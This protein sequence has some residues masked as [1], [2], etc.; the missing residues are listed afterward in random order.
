MTS[1]YVNES[2]TDMRRKLLVKAKLFKKDMNWKFVWTKNGKIFL[3]H[4]DNSKVI[5]ITLQKNLNDLV[6]SYST[7]QTQPNSASDTKIT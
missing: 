6:T 4:T 3:R 7:K 5:T 1:I 2:R